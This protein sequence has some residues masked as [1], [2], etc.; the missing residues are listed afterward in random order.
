MAR[1]IAASSSTE[2][3]EMPYQTFCT[4]PHI[5][6]RWSILAISCLAAALTAADA[7]AGSEFSNAI[8]SWSPRAPIRCTAFSRSASGTSGAVTRMAARACSSAAFTVGSVSW[9]SAAFTCGSASASRCLNTSLAAL[10]RLAGSGSRSVSAPTAALMAL[11]MRLLTRT[12]LTS[13]IVS[14]GRRRLA[15][16]GDEELVVVIGDVD[17]LVLPDIE[18]AVRERLEDRRGARGTAVAEFVD[19]LERGIVIAGGELCQRIFDRLGRGRAVAADAARAT[20]TNTMLEETAEIG[21]T[22][23]NGLSLLSGRG[24][25]RRCRRRPR[26]SLFFRRG[27]FTSLV[28]RTCRSSR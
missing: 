10:R 8:A 28:R 11:R 25:R 12:E 9:A 27:G 15:R 5:A 26:Q 16:C 3:S 20:A 21:T 23:A 22:S 19:A 24:G 17:R 1:P 7:L 13:S 6:R 14:V 2:P 4:A 18:I